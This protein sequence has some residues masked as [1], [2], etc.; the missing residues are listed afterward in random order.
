MPQVEQ[1]GV[2][3]RRR[4]DALVGSVSGELADAAVCVYPVAGLGAI[5]SHRITM[6]RDMPFTELG[7]AGLCVATLSADSLSLCPVAPGRGRDPRVGGVAVFGQ[8]RRQRSYTLHAG[9]VQNS[10][11]VTLL[12]E[13][14]GRLDGDRRELALELAY[15]V[16]ETL[17]GELSGALD[18]MMRGLTPLFGGSLL[19]G[20]AVVRR[21]GRAADAVLS[22]HGE[23]ERAEAASGTLEQARLA[24]AACH[25]VAQ[26]LDESL[27]LDGLARDLLTS[28]SRLCAAFR[29]EMGES[30]G[31]YVRRV[32]MERAAGLLEAPS[33]S[34]AEAARAVGYPR[35]SS[36]TA[37][38]E[39][40]HGCS[41]SEWRSSRGTAG[42]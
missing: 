11:S 19:D 35:A 29:Q 41:P 22:W 42:G 37:A 13:W 18:R 9:S 23:R 36:F 20:G 2:R 4:G 6:R 16:G 3:L 7:V 5:T 38:F 8:D 14:L 32:R 39:A 15:G 34:V 25:H 17:P 12:P 21:V 33:V 1:F 31:A 30:L 10:V 26:H 40:V 28:R 27:T 24:R